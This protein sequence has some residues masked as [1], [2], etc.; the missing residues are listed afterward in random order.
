MK[1]TLLQMACV[2]IPKGLGG[3]LT[4]VLNGVLLARMTPAEFGVY[5]VCLTLVILAE[6]VLGTAIDMSAV[7]IASAYS[8][9]DMQRVVAVEQ[10]AIIV[11]LGVSALTLSTLL[12]FAASASQA[13]FHRHDPILLALTLSVAA[14]VLMM[15]SLST[16]L[17]LRQRFGAYA[18][19]ELLAQALRV[20]GIAAVLMWFDPSAEM[21]IW[22]ALAGTLLSLIGGLQITQLR[23]QH[24][25]LEWSDGKEFLRTLR[26]MLATIAFSSLLSRID[27][28]LLTRWS[29]IEQVGV[30]AAAQLF[31]LI[32]EMLGL[33]LTVVFS[34]RV[35]P[36]RADGTLL[37]LMARVQICLGAFAL[38]V[39]FGAWILLQSGAIGL[40]ASYGQST[41]VLM[42]LL[43][44]AL[45]GMLALPVTMPYLL[46][47]RPRFTLAFDLLSLP[48]LVLVYH[49]AISESG[50]VGA[51]W[52][53]GGTRI[54]KAVVLQASAWWW[55][56]QGSNTLTT[57]S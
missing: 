11:K 40:P 37:R 32:P 18:S 3:V 53:S 46:F 51:A 29:S 27:L 20:C 43:I 49:W 5:S 42:P 30:F 41:E 33:W 14:G 23:W 57:T 52:V 8:R 15:R 47:T 24:W 25:C 56:R 21:L 6:A 50:A 31:A 17:Q 4:I 9:C 39:G 54:I 38:V 48:L 34:P 19:L 16:H 55:A 1:A 26:W 13:L 36:A 7:K 28:L 2:T 44:G 22:A 35:V 10:W 45:T 12:A